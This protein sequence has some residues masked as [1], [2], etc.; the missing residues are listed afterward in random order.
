M[1]MN[2]SKFS[3]NVLIIISSITLA[4]Y[5]KNSFNWQ[6]IKTAGNH[7]STLLQEQHYGFSCNGDEDTFGY[8]K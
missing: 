4:L 1:I 6:K 3:Q 7:P 5:N 2:H 8:Y